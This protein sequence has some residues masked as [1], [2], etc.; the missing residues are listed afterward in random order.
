[1]DDAFGT[2]CFLSVSNLNFLTA[3]KP[4]IGISSPI[5]EWFP[6]REWAIRIPAIILI[7]G[8]WTVGGFI[9]LTVVKENRRKAEKA[10]LRAA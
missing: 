3:R 6:A 4:F 5:H 2:F 1:V 9:G 7:V 10:R 8:L